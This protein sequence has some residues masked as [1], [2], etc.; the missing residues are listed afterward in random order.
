M[1]GE[2]WSPNEKLLSIVTV[3]DLRHIRAYPSL[4]TPGSMECQ[5][6]GGSPQREINLSSLGTCFKP[7]STYSWG[8]GASHGPY[9]SK[10]AMPSALHNKPGEVTSVNGDTRPLHRPL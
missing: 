3:D 6:R 2:Y 8:W 4:F 10:W 9:A 7:F 5:A 1:V